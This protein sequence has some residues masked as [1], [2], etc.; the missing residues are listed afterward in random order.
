MVRE[1]SVARVLARRGR[2]PIRGWSRHERRCWSSTCRGPSVP[3]EVPA[4]RAIVL[5][6]R[7]AAG[8]RDLGGTVIRCAHRNR[9]VGEGLDGDRFHDGLMAGRASGPRFPALA[10]GAGSPLPPE[11]EPRPG[12]LSAVKNRCSAL[13]PDAS[14]PDRTLR[15]RAS[16]PCGSRAARPPSAA[17]PRPATRCC[18]TTRRYCWPTPRPRGPGRSMSPRASGSSRC[19]ATC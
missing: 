6:T 8:M 17:N 9:R 7:L 3:S 11:L 13:V 12:G 16:T 2:L 5:A 19:P 14:D 4:A 18:R 10:R 15:G 1:E